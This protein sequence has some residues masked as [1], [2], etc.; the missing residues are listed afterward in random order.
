MATL[1]NFS[2]RYLVCLETDGHWDERTQQLGNIVEE[3]VARELP[4]PRYN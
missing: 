4:S 2:A 3:Q 1:K